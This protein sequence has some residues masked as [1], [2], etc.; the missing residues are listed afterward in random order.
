MSSFT[1]LDNSERERRKLLDLVVLGQGRQEDLISYLLA[2][3]P[4]VD[5]AAIVAE[6]RINLSPPIHSASCH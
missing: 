5:H 3:I 2:E 4:E 1:W 6:L